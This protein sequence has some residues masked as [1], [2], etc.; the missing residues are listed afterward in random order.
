MAEEEQS[1]HDKEQQFVRGGTLK[2][3]QKAQ[4]IAALKA[5]NKIVHSIDIRAL[6]ALEVSYHY[7]TNSSDN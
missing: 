6:E 1:V 2:S 7:R 3:H 5:K 4:A